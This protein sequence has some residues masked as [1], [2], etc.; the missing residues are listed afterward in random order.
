MD[1]NEVAEE[2][3][4]IE[5]N[6]MFSPQLFVKFFEFAKEKLSLE[7]PYEQIAKICNLKETGTPGCYSQQKGL[8][9]YTKTKFGF[10]DIRSNIK[11]E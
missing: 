10:I 11:Q 7:D 4:K 2:F 5:G 1:I 8:G 9:Y 3:V 6:D